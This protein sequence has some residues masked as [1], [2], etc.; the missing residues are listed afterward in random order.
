MLNPITI[1]YPFSPT[2]KSLATQQ[3]ADLFSI[4]DNALSHTVA[5]DVLLDVKPNDLVLFSGPSGS[6]KSSLMREVARQLN[7][8]DV[9]A[10]SLPEVP[11]VDALPGEVA[12]RLNQL[13]A[14]GLS[15][16]RL[17]MRL[18]TQLSDGERYRFRVALGLTHQRP[19]MLDE[20]GA[21]LDR[22][23]AK[24]LAFNLRKL[25]SRTGIGAFCATTHTD[26]IDDLNP[27]L[28]IHCMGDGHIEVQRR[29]VKKKTS[30]LPTIYG[31]RMAPV[32]TGRTSHG[33]IIAVTH[34]RSARKS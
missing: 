27:D 31:S 4:S 19:L 13:A 6:G 30:A 9:M 29:D 24:V 2:R 14:C 23:L 5:E 18:P 34:S 22:T 11:I 3:V 20:F 12:E 26:L 7:A 8:V 28:H 21:V 15:E 10:L 33:G 17:L 1:R 25:V 32:P 16:A